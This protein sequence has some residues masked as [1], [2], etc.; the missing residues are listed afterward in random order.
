M[1]T[2][3][4]NIRLSREVTSLAREVDALIK[5]SDIRT[6][7]HYKDQLQNKWWEPAIYTLLFI[8]GLGFILTVYKLI[9]S[10]NPMIFWFVFGWVVLFVLTLI[11]TLEFLMLKI[12]ALRKLYDHQNR[13]IEELIKRSEQAN[14]SKDEKSGQTRIT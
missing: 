7:Y 5:I 11:A 6:S 1:A 12:A 8:S 9:P 14:I 13:L 2:L 3:P 4:E 10:H